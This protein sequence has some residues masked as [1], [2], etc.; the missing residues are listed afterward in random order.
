MYWLQMI[1]LGCD[2]VTDWLADNELA[3]LFIVCCIVVAGFV[4]GS[5]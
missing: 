2:V 1:L 4:E 5:I 3:W